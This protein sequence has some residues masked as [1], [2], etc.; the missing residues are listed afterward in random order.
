VRRNRGGRSLAVELLEISARCPSLPDLDTRAANE[1]FGY[2][3][4]GLPQ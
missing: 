2:D 4:R 3:E 1:I